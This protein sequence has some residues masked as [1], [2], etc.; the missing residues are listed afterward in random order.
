ME[1]TLIKL[2]ENLARIVWQTLNKKGVPTRTS[3]FGLMSTSFTPSELEQVTTL[4]LVNFHGSLK[5][6]SNLPNLHSLSITTTGSPAFKSSKNLCSITDNDIFEIEKLTNLKHLSIDNQRLIS[7][8]DISRFAHLESL[9][10]T[11]NQ[12][13]TEIIGLANNRSIS[14]LTLYDLNSLLPIKN[15]DK[16]ITDNQELFETN[17]DVLLFPQAIGFKPTTRSFNQTA[18]G[19]LNSDIGA[20]ATW[21]ETC[22]DKVIRINNHQITQMHGKALDIV[23]KYCKNT[24]DIEAVTIIEQ[25]LAKNVKYNYSALDSTLRGEMR[26][27]ILA[28]PVK[29]AN[30][31]YNAFM[32][33][34]CVCEGYTRAMQYMLALKGIHTGNV[35]CISGEDK[36]HMA[37]ANY[38]N[39]YAIFNLPKS[40][41]HSIC[42]IERDSGIYYCDPCW[43][44]CAYQQGNK[45]L[46]YLLKTKAEIS[47]DHTLSFNEQVVSHQDPIPTQYLNQIKQIANQRFQESSKQN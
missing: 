37:D 16:F 23:N 34:S 1:E 15:F 21:C 28:G 38:D 4:N 46:P 7:Q 12:E 31:A 27:G 33:N 45:T 26:D 13:L 14:S 24:S 32:Y 47:K 10:L 36:L 3:N 29:G 22:S 5:G 9:Q 2:P 18:L 35:H 25:Y 41:Y 20:F 11:R 8:I 43:D 30:G 17:L 42:R 44:A 40:G 19:K 39:E 6:L